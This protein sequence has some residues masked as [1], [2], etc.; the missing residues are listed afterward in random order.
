M[1]IDFWLRH[2]CKRV[3]SSQQ[4]WHFMFVVSEKMRKAG[5]HLV[6]P[7]TCNLLF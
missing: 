2:G 7:P 6:K 1:M 3:H 5:M 4:G